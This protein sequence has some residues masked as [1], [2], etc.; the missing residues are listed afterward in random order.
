VSKQP[1]V[2]ALE[3]RKGTTR[4]ATPR[5]APRAPRPIIPFSA[6]EQLFNFSDEFGAVYCRS[7]FLQVHRRDNPVST[8][9]AF[10][11]GKFTKWP[12]ETLATW[13]RRGPVLGQLRA[14]KWGIRG[15][16]RDREG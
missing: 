10:H 9:W 15:I 13:W 4:Q 7:W 14:L 2:D 1:C 8:V 16:R 11:T 6:R 5:P 12:S 3:L